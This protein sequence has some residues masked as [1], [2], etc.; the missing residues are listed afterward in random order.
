MKGGNVFGRILTKYKKAWEKGDPDLAMELFT[1]D[2]T[3][4]GDPFD[5]RPMRGL[6]EIRDYWSQVPK[7]QK[8]VQFS[9]GPI[10]RL[11]QSRVWG[12]EWSARYVKVKTR[13]RVKLKGVLFCELG[14]ERIRRFWEY[15]HVRGGEP[16]FRAK[17]SWRHRAA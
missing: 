11:G 6:P 10:F 2:A 4:L 17:T 8:D 9:R 14:G 7:F 12:V 16:S 1:P 13:E 5:A 3:Y 15:W